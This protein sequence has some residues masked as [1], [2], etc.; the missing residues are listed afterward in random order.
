MVLFTWFI[1]PNHYDEVHYECYY[2]VLLRIASPDF[3]H[4]LTTC[5]GI[6]YSDFG[7]EHWLPY[8]AVRTNSHVNDDL[9]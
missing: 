7:H 5:F 3:G 4:G 1:R 8:I 2:S 9:T 6:V